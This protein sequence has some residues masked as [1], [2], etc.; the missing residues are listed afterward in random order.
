[1]KTYPLF[2]LLSAAALAQADSSPFDGTWK[3]NAGKS[4]LTGDTFTYTKTATGYTR[5]SAHGGADLEFA[6]DGKDYQ[7]KDGVVQNWTAAG[8]DAWDTLVK[9]QGKVI[10]ARHVVLAGDGKTLT[11]TYT[12]DLADGSK[13]HGKI[14]RTR[15]GPGTGL[16]GTWKTIEYAEDPQ[17]A[18]YSTP[19]PGYLHIE[20]RGDA[21]EGPT[22]GTEFEMKGADVPPDWVATFKWVNAQ[23]LAWTGGHHGK[24][25]YTGT[26]TVSPDGKTLTS[27]SWAIGKESE[28]TRMVYDKQ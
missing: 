20:E 26:N 21:L 18:V 2:V 6:V 7:D 28:K 13:V 11:W 27:V 10:E 24:P 23:E 5:S 4:H 9:V 25:E 1:M 14:V 22:D 17:V 3:S 12:S 16:A 19:K 8:N 15:V